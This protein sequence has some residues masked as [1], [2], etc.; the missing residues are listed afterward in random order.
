MTSVPMLVSIVAVALARIDAH[1]VRCVELLLARS[2][3]I[4]GRKG[5]AMSRHAIRACSSVPPVKQWGRLVIAV[6]SRPI[7]S[8]RLRRGRW[9]TVAGFGIDG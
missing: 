2:G 9:A 4:E 1:F 5:V 7:A 6:A 3:T 8:Q